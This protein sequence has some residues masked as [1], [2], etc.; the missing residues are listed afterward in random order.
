MKTLRDVN[1]SVFF[2]T[3]L[4][5]FGTDSLA[6]PF[7]LGYQGRILKSDNTPLTYNSVSFIFK[8]TDPSGQ[9]IVYQEQAT[10]ID[11]T[12]SGGVFDVP[13]G[14]G[15]VAFP[16][17]GS[18][19]ILDA[20]NNSRSFACKDSSSTYTSV[21]GDNR[22]LRVMFY[23]GAGWNTISPDV[24]VRTVPYSAY[25]ASAEKLGTHNISDF[26]LKTG[27]PTC[28]ASSFLTYDGTNLIC[29]A[30]AG[31]SGGT[32]TSVTSGNGYISVVN[33][34]TTPQLT[35][36]V[37]T[38]ASTVA[39]GN[40]ARIVNAVQSGSTAGGDLAGTYPNPTVAQ[41]QGTSVSN[42]APASGQFFKF[43]G[44]S[45]IP[46]NIA[47]A[48]VTNLNTSLSSYL[49]QTA[50]NGYV[51][52]ASCSVNQTLYWNSVGGNFQCQSINVGLAGDVTGSIG[53]SVVSAV[54]GSSA[55]NVHSAELL[56][57]A[58]TSANTASTLVKRDGS[59]NFAASAATLT[60]VVLKDS[61]SNTATLKAPNAIGTSYTLKLPTDI[62]SVNGQVLSSD[63]SGNLSWVTP[64]TTATSYSGVLPIANG[65]TNSA[66]A[67]NN[68]RLMISNAGAIVEAPALTNGQ[69]LIGSTGAA[70]TAATLASGTGINI[71]NGAG[72]ITIATT[73][74]LSNSLAD[75][76]IWVGQGGTAAAVT[77]GGDVS[78]TNAGA[79]TVNAL[80]GKAVSAAP[81]LTGQVLRYD[82]TSWTPNYVSMQDLRSTVTGASSVTS[83]TAG[84]TLT[85]TSVADN[86]TCTNIAIADSQI[87]YGSQAAKTFLAAPTG[88]AGTP[89]Y[90]TIAT[91]DL[92]AT[93]VSGTQSTSTQC[94]NFTT[95]NLQVSSYS[96]TNTI[97]IGGLADGGAYTVVLTGY[98]AGQTVTVNAFTDTGCSTPVAT[99]VDFGGST[100]A[101]TSTFTASG[102]TQLVTFIYSSAR[103]VVYASA[104]TNFYH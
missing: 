51:A 90:R 43:N 36:N 89:V 30:V 39:A 28:P 99:G 59:G 37:G 93:L 11:M 14:S 7:S 97:N 57:N 103:G 83:C 73:G 38:A 102:N 32:V 86:L 53:A 17:D 47:I 1:V 60:S 26:I 15:S 54:G 21:S 55:A 29:S 34:T 80:K 95:G 6:A 20:F 81:T 48:D 52:S 25:A 10:G 78:M 49:T 12:N 75:G 79:V 96:S 18:V 50:F 62:A 84:Q 41:L 63:T 68:N 24:V 27:V 2:L 85:Y 35:L 94:I 22:K 5:L 44:T 91:A 23:D 8:I 19:G 16:T 13:I 56:A 92:P 82:G 40:D 45:W 100:S 33:N 67:L 61:G 46:S 71:T 104:A 31:A 65:G 4:M 77:P 72:T 3:A 42:T 64:S 69:L 87:S 74:L 98:T 76:K 70:P 66:V 88:S 101:V 9:C 58:A